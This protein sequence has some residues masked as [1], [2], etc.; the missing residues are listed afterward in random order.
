M[1]HVALKLGSTSKN[2]AAR[3]YYTTCYEASAHYG[4]IIATSRL[5]TANAKN[6]NA[7]RSAKFIPNKCVPICASLE[8]GCTE[9]A[10]FL[11]Q[12]TGYEFIPSIYHQKIKN[13]GKNLAECG[14]DSFT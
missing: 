14:S 1:E 8:L 6:S 11:G 7:D 13:V 4:N 12:K 9:L 3:T 2:C 10:I 5:H